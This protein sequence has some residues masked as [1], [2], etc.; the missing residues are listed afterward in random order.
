MDIYTEELG[1]QYP[2]SDEKPVLVVTEK[3]VVFGD[4]VVPRQCGVEGE[5]K[6][7]ALL[8]DSDYGYEL[9]T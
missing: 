9:P 8:F 3:E 4:L 5:V 2:L 7:V 1:G 6:L